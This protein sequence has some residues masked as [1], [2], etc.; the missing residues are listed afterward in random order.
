MTTSIAKTPSPTATAAD[1][2]TE[3]ARLLGIA[4]RSWADR[5][6]SW[7]LG[8][9]LV[10]SVASAWNAGQGAAAAAAGG[11]SESAA[12]LSDPGVLLLM[13]TKGGAGAVL[14]LMALSLTRPFETGMADAERLAVPRGWQWPL[15]RWGAA[16]AL[17]VA[18]TLVVAP[19]TWHVAHVAG[20]VQG[21]GAGAAQAMDA[22]R[23]AMAG[24]LALG[25]GLVTALV[26]GI[27]SLV[28]NSA[29]VLSLCG[30]WFVLGEEIAA[31]AP[32]LHPVAQWLPLANLWHF[33]GFTMSSTAVPSWSPTTS[34]LLLATTSALVFAVGVWRSY[35]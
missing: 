2:L 8:S 34:G 17:I 19:L 32:V 29:V 11:A 18:A 31:I 14:V 6:V 35:R 7:A 4:G 12:M 9:V 28:R 24:R 21:T 15:S 16:A 3:Q 26:A 25:L 22:A 5:R 13:W 30:L 20:G 10:L 23:W 27:A 1:L 33:V